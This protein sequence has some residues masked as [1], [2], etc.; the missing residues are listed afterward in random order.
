MIEHQAVDRPR[1]PLRKSP[2]DP[3]AVQPL[4]ARVA[5]VFARQEHDRAIAR[6]QFGHIVGPV[7]IDVIAIGPV[8]PADRVQILQFADTVFERI[9]ACSKIQ[10]RHCFLS[11]YNCMLD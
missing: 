4:D 8:Q 1:A 3:V 11:R 2:G 10:F 7:E 6:K 9:E 5:M